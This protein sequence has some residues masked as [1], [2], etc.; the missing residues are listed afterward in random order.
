MIEENLVGNW[1][2]Y[3]SKFFLPEGEID[4]MSGYIIVFIFCLFACGIITFFLYQRKKGVLVEYGKMGLENNN[5]GS[6]G[7]EME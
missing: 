3:Y 7:K 4:Y 2:K 6:S 5:P 1:V